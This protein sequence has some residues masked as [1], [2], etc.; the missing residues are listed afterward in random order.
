MSKNVFLHVGLPKSGTSY[1]QKTLTA[2]KDCLKREGLLFPGNGWVAQVRA[3]QDVRQMKLAPSKRKGVS[4]AWDKLV[5]EIAAWP[6]DAIV[7]MEWLGPATPEH[8][9][10]IVDDL[11]PARVQV[12]FTAR[13][14]AR[15]VPAAWQEFMQN[16]EEWTWSEFLDSVVAD[17]APPTSPGA[18]FWAQQDLAALLGNWTS[19]VPVEDVHVV[20][21]PH[22]GAG[23]DVLWQ[24]MCQVLGSDYAHDRSAA[25]SNTAAPMIKS[26]ERT[27]CPPLS[28]STR[29]STGWPRVC[30]PSGPARSP[31][32]CYRP[33]ITSGHGARRPARS[34]RCGLPGCTS[35]ETSRSCGR[36]STRSP[37][38]SRPTSP[39]RRCWTSPSARSSPWHASGVR[40]GTPRPACGRRMLGFVSGWSTSSGTRAGRSCDGMR[41]RLGR[42]PRPCAT[43]RAE[44]FFPNFAEAAR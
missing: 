20:T 41:A 44:R 19:N 27:A 9:R 43:A 14:L 6:G 3:V 4:G 30:S 7:S 21:L 11:S 18:R 40:R 38:S 17:E 16:R 15:T 22:P 31:S 33:R 12:I 32:S 37:G 36:W 1:V 10:A 24:R 42:G 23:P 8:I 5:A 26:L 28:T 2:N 25:G 13:D 35:S 39:T 29:S 34:R